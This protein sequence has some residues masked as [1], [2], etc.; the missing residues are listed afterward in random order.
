LTIWH[1]ILS[2]EL[3][4][5]HSYRPGFGDFAYWVVALYIETKKS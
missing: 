1:C 5:T 3:T 4:K 2:Y